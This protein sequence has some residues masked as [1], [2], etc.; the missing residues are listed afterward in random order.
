MNWT[1]KNRLIAGCVV[2]L[3]V[4]ALACAYGLQQMASAEGSIKAIAKRGEVNMKRMEGAHDAKADLLDAE[5]NRTG[6]L[7]YKQTKLIDDLHK[8]LKSAREA[9]G[10]VVADTAADDALHSPVKSALA[11]ADK[12][13]KSV[14]DMAELLTKRGLTPELGLEGNLRT[15]VHTVE[16]LVNEQ[17]LAELSVLML[18]CRRHEKDYF[19]R[20]DAKYL[21][22]IA[23]RIEEFTAQMKQFS[24]PAEVQAKANAAFKDYFANMQAIVEIDK[25][26]KTIIA[27]ADANAAEF[28]KTVDAVNN[29]LD[30]LIAKDRK[31][32]LDVMATGKFVMLVLLI[33]GLCLGVAVAIVLVRTISPPLEAIV[34]TLQTF[35]AQTSSAAGQISNSSQSLAEGASEQA[36]S[37]EETSASLEE[38]ASMTKRNAEAAQNAKQVAGKARSVADSGTAGM[39]RMTEAMDGIKTSSSE[40]AKIIKTIDEIAFQ[41]NI[42]ALNAAVEA[43]RAGEAGAGFAVVAE[44]VRNLAQRSAQAAKETASKIEAALVK[45][46]EGARASSEVSGI[47]NEIVGQVRSM[48][49]LVAE[50]A[51]ASG[52]QS[53]GIDQVNIAVSQMDKVTQGNAASAEESAAAAEELTAQ[54]NELQSLV[55][56][57]GMMVGVKNDGTA[58]KSAP[59]AP[60]AKRLGHATSA[61]Q[62]PAPKQATPGHRPAAAAATAAAGKAGDDFWK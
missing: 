27:D 18:M 2:L 3:V 54:S 17:G 12:Y 10:A 37:L 60:A 33:V 34:R 36:A 40:I 11:N 46:E 8:D 35:V 26:I 50:I 59:P 21:A 30:E 58:V 44:E 19:L 22:E 49:S 7:L 24:L 55:Q 45:S 47:L 39:Q 1:I 57:L 41:T 25:S 42:L 52:E 48:D 62:L 16:T 53:Q 56:N 61:K 14:N 4:I 51:N 43:A 6:F 38:M 20:G 5:A 13:E 28:D 31:S 29:S 9:L 23:K 15:S 32:S